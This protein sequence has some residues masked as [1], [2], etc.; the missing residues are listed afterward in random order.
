[1]TNPTLVPSS[2]SARVEFALPCFNRSLDGIPALILV[3]EVVRVGGERARTLVRNGRAR[4]MRNADAC[5]AG[6][7]VHHLDGTGTYKVPIDARI[8]RAIALRVRARHP[9]AECV[10]PSAAAWAAES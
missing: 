5:P 9:A 7:R 4:Q 8:I 1:M 10:L 3:H 2:I 6:R